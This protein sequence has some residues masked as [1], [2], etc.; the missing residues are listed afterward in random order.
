[1]FGQTHTGTVW[2]DEIQLCKPSDSEIKVA[3]AL[4]TTPEDFHATL[5][6]DVQLWHGVGA[7]FHVDPSTS[8]R[9]IL[10]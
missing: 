1:M 7:G 10:R 4:R 3:T 9:Q 6:T 2:F 8:F 5:P